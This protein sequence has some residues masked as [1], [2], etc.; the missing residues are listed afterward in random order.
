MLYPGPVW[1]SRCR[2]GTRGPVGGMVAAVRTQ[3]AGPLPSLLEGTSRLQ[4]GRAWR[5]CSSDM[6]QKAVTTALASVLKTTSPSGRTVK[7]LGRRPTSTSAPMSS[8]AVSR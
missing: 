5:R 7:R 3:A 6:R 8:L 4:A 1:P 2:P